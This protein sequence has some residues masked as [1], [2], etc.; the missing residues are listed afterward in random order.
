[1]LAAIADSDEELAD[2]LA[3]HGAAYTVRE[4]VAFH[5]PQDVQRMVQADPTLL[6]QTF[7]DV[8]PTGR[9]RGTEQRTLLAMA[10]TRGYR[11]IADFL[12]DAGSSLDFVSDRSADTLLHLAARAGDNYLARRLIEARLDLNPLN[13]F[14]W[15]PLHYA[16][17]GDRPELC[18]TLIS[19]GA[20]VNAHADR[21]D[22][23]L[24]VAAS[25]NNARL[26][27][28]LL[29]KGADPGFR[30]AYNQIARDVIDRSKFP[31]LVAL[32]DPV[33]SRRE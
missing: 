8:A 7:L 1:M 15:T 10:I 21:G 30:N 2:L 27:H 16:V 26:I 14:G 17:R 18:A 20:D 3:K 33:R 23:P 19:A 29:E 11:D 13:L 32:L 24:H 4:A 5:R 9:L 25:Q 31:E 28:F 22:T 12:L 6:T